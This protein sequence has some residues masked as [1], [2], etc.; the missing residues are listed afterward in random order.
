MR[1]ASRGRLPTGVRKSIHFGPESGEVGE[2]RLAV[3]APLA[4]SEQVAAVLHLGDD[5]GLDWSIAAP[6]ARRFVDSQPKA[7]PCIPSQPLTANILED[8]LPHIV[9]QIGRIRSANTSAAS[10]TGARWLAAR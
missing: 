10:A 2:A 3:R 5:V 7:L 1:A 9:A 6:V 8:V 4:L